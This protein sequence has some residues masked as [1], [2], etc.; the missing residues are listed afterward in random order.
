MARFLASHLGGRDKP[1]SLCPWLYT[2]IHASIRDMHFFILSLE[3]SLKIC[4]S[5]RGM[6]KDTHTRVPSSVHQLFPPLWAQ[7]RIKH[8][9]KKTKRRDSPSLQQVRIP[10]F[11]PI[12]IFL[13]RVLNSRP[14]SCLLL[15]FDVSH[16]N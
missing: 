12:A 8:G 13:V 10:P 1:F 2:F 5:L 7:K 3:T 14:E 16:E 6:R 15:A 4:L 9:E 11:R